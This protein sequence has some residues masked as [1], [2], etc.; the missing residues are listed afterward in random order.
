MVKS[1]T[2]VSLKIHLLD[3]IAQI[4]TIIKAG[5]FHDNLRLCG[6]NGFGVGLNL[7]KFCLCILILLLQFLGLAE[8]LMQLGY[9]L[10]LLNSMFES[11]SVGL[12]ELLLLVVKV[13]GSGES[14]GELGL[15][16]VS[17]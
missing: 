6:S 5:P 12:G 17:F 11:L 2:I 7:K 1:L 13:L 4:L 14:L 15:K 10:F 8:G 3:K 9:F 16:Q